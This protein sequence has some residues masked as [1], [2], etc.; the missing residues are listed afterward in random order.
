MTG[1]RRVL[2]AFAVIGLVATACGTGASPTPGPATIRVQLQWVPQ[3]QFAGE[4]A[5]LELGY[6]TAENLKVELVPGG[7]NVANVTV[8]SAADGPEFTLAWVPKALEAVQGGNSDLVSIAQ[9][10][11]RSGTRSV[12]WKDSNITSV[13][14]FKGK[15]IGVWDFGNE[16]EVTAGAK[17]NGLVVGTDYEK[18]IQDFNMAALLARQI[19]VA[20]AMTY[21][22]YAQ[23]LEVIN[24]DTGKLYQAEDLNLIDWNTEG[25]AMLQ[26][27]VFARKAWLAQ[28][29]NEDV[30][31]RFLRATFRGW[32][33]CRDNAAKC[34]DYVLA[35]GTTLGKGHQAWQMNE[36]NPLIWPSPSGIGITD[37]ALWDQTIAVAI[38]GGVLTAAP[39]DGAYRNDLAE[40]ALAGIKEDTKGTGFTKGTVEVTEG[41]N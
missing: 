17:K 33:Y 29:G 24:P 39:P 36:V 15:K 28:A 37:K 16:Y 11:Q 35:A 41:G 22:E 9:I 3:A 6:Y 12:S 31:V 13:A 21:N 38:E 1:S 10:F 8:G 5:A 40:K 30:A 25:T 27:A 19:D 14:Q 34:V 23:L 2:A 20:E 4:F 32:I 7:P 18:V 26:D